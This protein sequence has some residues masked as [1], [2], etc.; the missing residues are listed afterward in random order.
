MT[1]FDHAILFISV[2]RANNEKQWFRLWKSGML[3]HGGVVD[4]TRN[5]CGTNNTSSRLYTVNLKWTYDGKTAPV[6][7]FPA[8]GIGGFYSQDGQIYT[9][10]GT[11][12]YSPAINALG[13]Q[14]RYIV[15]ISPLQS[16][17]STAVAGGP[18]PA[19]VC[20]RFTRYPG[21]EVTSMNNDS[22]TFLYAPNQ[23]IKFYSYYVK[24]FTVN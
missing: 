5:T 2:N 6:Y 1:G 7:N 4:I 20:D 9:G 10:S 17:T 18:Y 11:V 23:K 24:G 16:V 21:K 13:S 12:D 19:V 22:F 8:V 3:E 15:D 14:K